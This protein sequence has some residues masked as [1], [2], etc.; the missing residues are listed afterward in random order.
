MLYQTQGVH[1]TL[2]RRHNNCNRIHIILL[3]SILMLPAAVCH[4]ATSGQLQAKQAR[5]SNTLITEYYDSSGHLALADDLKYARIEQQ[6]DDSG[7][8]I[9]E[10]YYDESGKSTELYAGHYG[11]KREYDK[12]GNNTK[13]TFLNAEGRSFMNTSGYC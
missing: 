13:V 10:M 5:H 7:R 9:K 12:A 11:L 2:K 8:V 3:L 6:L 4:A 1:R